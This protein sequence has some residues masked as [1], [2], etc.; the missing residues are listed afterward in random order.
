MALTIPPNKNTK[1]DKLLV[2]RAK[3]GDSKAFERLMKKYRKSVYYMILRMVRNADDADDL[4][5][6][7]FA[8]AFTSIHNFDAKFAFSTWLFRIASNNSIDYVRKKRLTTVSINGDKEGEDGGTIQIDIKDGALDPEEVQLKQQRHQYL[9]MALD[10]IPESF[11]KLVELRYFD[12]LSYEE[13]AQH[14]EIP[15]GTVK[16]KLFRS[17]EL[18]EEEMKKVIHDL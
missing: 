7:A 18:I 5:Q 4:T 15:L 3:E 14:L 1:E 11:R 16:A 13:I 2:Q 10:R 12:E 9:R 8:K 17:R 6:E